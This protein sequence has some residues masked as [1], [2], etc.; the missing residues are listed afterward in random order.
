MKKLLLSLFVAATASLG[1]QAQELLKNPAM[2]EW[3]DAL[4]TAWDK[5][6]Q[7]ATNVT[8]KEYATGRTGKAVEIP[9]LKFEKN[10][11]TSYSNTRFCQRINLKA[12]KYLLT[13]WAKGAVEGK[14]A[15]AGFVPEKNTTGL[16]N[17]SSYT[18]GKPYTALSTTEWKQVSYTFEIEKDGLYWVVLFN[19]KSEGSIY[20]DDASL[21]YQGPSS[22]QT[23]QLDTE[24]APAYDLT[25]RRV[26]ADQKGIVVVGGV[27]RLNR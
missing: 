18:Y 26:A 7:K 2:E 1:L 13:F 19:S 22:V 5:V 14:E 8:V 16:P 27:K 15:A 20:V 4:P 24:N 23:L 10:G 21:T 12:G 9:H 3:A 11:K 6:E 25:G 17:S